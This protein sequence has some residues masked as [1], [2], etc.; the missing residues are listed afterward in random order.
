MKNSS[1]YKR[2]ESIRQFLA[3]LKD[4]LVIVGLLLTIAI[5]LHLL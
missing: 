5:K 1:R 3:I 2:Y 4:F